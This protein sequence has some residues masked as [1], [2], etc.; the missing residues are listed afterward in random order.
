MATTEQATTAHATQAELT[1]V[2]QQRAQLRAAVDGVEAV[3]SSALT[4][5]TSKWSAEITPA[6]SRLRDSINH[7]VTVTEGP[8]GLF[9][10]IQ[11][12][13]PRLSGAVQR[14]HVEHEQFQAEVDDVLTT[15]SESPDDPVAMGA[16]REQ[17]TLL[18]GRI[19][20]HRQKGADLI[21]DAYEV[22]IG[23]G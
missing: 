19:V 18:I 8:G 5:R 4:G 22:D 10:Q 20:R 11:T 17:I 3:L 2:T 14:L 15:L 13:S 1:G 9:E 16:L 12:D 23:G 6:M 21:Y 7:H